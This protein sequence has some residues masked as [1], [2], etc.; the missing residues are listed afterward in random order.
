MLKEIENWYFEG[1]PEFLEK[2]QSEIERLIIRNP[3]SER[4]L[5]LLLNP[6]LASKPVLNRYKRESPPN[7]IGTAF[8][9]AGVSKLDYPYHGY[10]NELSPHMKLN[11]P[12]EERLLEAI[13]GNKHPENMIPGAFN[14]SYCVLSDGWHAG[15]Y[16]GRVEDKE[17]LFAQHGHGRPFG[18][19]TEKCYASPK[20]FI[21]RTLNK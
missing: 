21:P 7:C 11:I 20:Y 8:W 19:E 18:I 15:I 9:V 3:F 14:F 6:Q 2:H 1:E 17:V 13:F 12:P 10:E 5:H 4:I 16:L